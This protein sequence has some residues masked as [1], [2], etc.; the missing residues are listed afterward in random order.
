MSFYRITLG[1]LYSISFNC[2]TR[3]SLAAPLVQL[4]FCVLALTELS[5]AWPHILE[6]DVGVCCRALDVFDH[7]D[8]FIGTGDPISSDLRH[9]MEVTVEV[10][11]CKEGILEHNDPCACGKRQE[12]PEAVDAYY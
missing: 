4:E 10:L 3:S 9:V 8:V 1:F 7:D 11:T 12:H 5:D 2:S 6:D